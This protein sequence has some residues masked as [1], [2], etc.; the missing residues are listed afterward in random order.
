MLTAFDATSQ[1]SSDTVCIPSSQLKRAVERIEECKLIKK[2]LD[3]TLERLA[4]AMSRLELRDSA[5][6][7][8][9]AMSSRQ[10]E[11]YRNAEERNKNLGR[12]VDN[13]EKA[14]DLQSKAYRRQRLSKWLAGA[15]GVAVGA[16]LIR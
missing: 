2:D 1:Q 10:D 7:S 15:I 16:T 6:S 9:R 14:L 13:L 4:L 3:L 5:I 8:L 11:L 12:Q